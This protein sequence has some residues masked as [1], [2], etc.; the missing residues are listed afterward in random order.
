MPRSTRTSP[1]TFCTFKPTR[2]RSRRCSSGSRPSGRAAPSPTR[3]SGPTSSSSAVPSTARSFYM[4]FLKAGTDSRGFIVGWAPALSPDFDRVPIAMAVSLALR[5]RRST[6][7]RLPPRG[8]AGPARAASGGSRQGREERAG[9]CRL[10]GR[11]GAHERDAGRRLLARDAGG[12]VGGAR[13]RRRPSS[14]TSRS[15][16]SRSPPARRGEMALGAAPRRRGGD[17]PRQR[18]RPRHADRGRRHGPERALTGHAAIHDGGRLAGR[19]RLRRG[20]RPRRSSRGQ[21]PP[22]SPSRACSSRH[23]CARSA[24]PCRRRV[25]RTRRSRACS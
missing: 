6:R 19:R 5:R 25:I 11:R 22:R 14:T 10:A 20:R 8:R 2:S 3:S 9:L 18:R 17:G 7:S 4:R 24:S 15:S 13:D 23:S 12:R 16:G 1:S 21:R